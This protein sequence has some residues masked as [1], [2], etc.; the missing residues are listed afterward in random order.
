MSSPRAAGEAWPPTPQPPGSPAFP[1]LRV[2]VRREQ[3]FQRRAAPAGWRTGYSV[4]QHRRAH[5]PHEREKPRRVSE[6]HSGGR[7][8]IKYVVVF[9]L[10]KQICPVS[11][12]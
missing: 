1:Q 6:A 10:I 4:T 3:L 9:F 2:L 8:A 7:C 5:V 11:L 12:H